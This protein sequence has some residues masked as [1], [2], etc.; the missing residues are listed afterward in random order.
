MTSGSCFWACEGQVGTLESRFLTFERRIW[1]L[2]VKLKATET[3]F[4]C[5]GVKFGTLGVIIRP[6]GVKFRPVR[7]KFRHLGVDF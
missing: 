1:A 2:L 3:Q 6:Q 4:W 5:L 7:V